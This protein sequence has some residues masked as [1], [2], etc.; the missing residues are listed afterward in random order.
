VSI[1]EKLVLALAL[2]VAGFAGGIKWHVGIVA[3]RDLAAVE[4]RQEKERN[5]RK[6]VDVAAVGHEKDKAQIRTVTKTVIQEVERIVREPFYVAAD[7]PAC[8][9]ADGLR[10]LETAIGAAQPAS[11]PA[12]ALPRP[13]GAR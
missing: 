4:A 11:K 7:A 1:A 3:A 5:D 8:L 6:A 10:Q 2:F 13:D 9:D 12:R